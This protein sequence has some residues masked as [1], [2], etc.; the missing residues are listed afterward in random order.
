MIFFSCMA[1]AELLLP[2]IHTLHTL[3]SGTHTAITHIPTEQTPHTTHKVQQ[4]YQRLPYQNPTREYQNLTYSEVAQTPERQVDNTTYHQ[5]PERKK[6][7]TRNTW[8]SD[9][10]VPY[11][12]NTEKIEPTQVFQDLIIKQMEKMDMLFSQM[13]L[14]IGLISALVDRLP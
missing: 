8:K 6:E 7:P 4:Q 14:L 3:T 11:N 10:K 13:T 12:T 2:R 5:R 1:G 9:E